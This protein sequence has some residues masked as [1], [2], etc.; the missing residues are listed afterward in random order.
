MRYGFKGLESSKKW[1][2]ETKNKESTLR[3]VKD[4]CTVNERCSWLV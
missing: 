2:L 4:T 3:Y 1:N